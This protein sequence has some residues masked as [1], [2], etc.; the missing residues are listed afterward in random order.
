M[1]QQK[2]DRINE[3]TKISR[4]REL[5]DDEKAEREQLRAEYRK[6]FLQSL[7]GQLDNITL[8]DPDGTKT[9]LKDI[10]KS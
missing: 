8:V 1:N 3:L 6:S 5:T 4:Q 2:L 7:S 10:K 9:N